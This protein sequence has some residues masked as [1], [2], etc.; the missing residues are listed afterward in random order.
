MLSK[1]FFLLLPLASFWLFPTFWYG[2]RMHTPM[3]L[4]LR[5]A[6]DLLTEPPI[7]TPDLEIAAWKWS[8][9]GYCSLPKCCPWPLICRG[10]STYFWEPLTV[11]GTQCTNKHDD[12]PS[13]TS[14][15]D[16]YPHGQRQHQWSAVL[17]TGVLPWETKLLIF[18]SKWIAYLSTKWKG[19]LQGL[20]LIYLF[21]FILAI[22]H[23]LL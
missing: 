22:S 6:N 11:Q 19:C 4:L 16:E 12:R 8:G 20:L 14:G 9:Q 17:S 10:T 1:S 7:Q 21:I 15:G 3:T 13:L 2:L 23:W 5:T 18:P